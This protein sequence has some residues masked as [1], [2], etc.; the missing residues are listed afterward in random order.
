MHTKLIVSVGSVG[1]TLFAGVLWILN[2]VRRLLFEKQRSAS[3]T[4][5]VSVIR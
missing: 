4:G 2:F 5:S 1:A 3:A